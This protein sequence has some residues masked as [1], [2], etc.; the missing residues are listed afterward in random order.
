MSAQTVTFR[1][2]SEKVKDLD[3]LAAAQQRDRTFVLNEAIDCYLSLQKHHR[4]LIEDG[5][6]DEQA[7]RLSSHDKVVALA[8][9][10]SGIK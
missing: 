2:Q 9:G 7:G 10:W 6:A 1:T 5:L 8:K 4:Q 3:S